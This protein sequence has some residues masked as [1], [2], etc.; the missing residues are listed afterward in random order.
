MQRSSVPFGPAESEAWGVVLDAIEEAMDVEGLSPFDRGRL[1]MFHE[2][3]AWYVG[4]GLV[5]PDDWSACRYTGEFAAVG[6]GGVLELEA[7]G[8][9]LWRAGFG[10]IADVAAASDEDLLA[11]RGVGPKRLPLIRAAVERYFERPA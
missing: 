8:S 3:A 2:V 10:R 11:I 4:A 9:T 1:A 5:M 6:P 7:F